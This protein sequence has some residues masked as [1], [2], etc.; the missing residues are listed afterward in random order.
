MDFG[1]YPFTV[2]VTIG[3]RRA[4]VEWNANKEGHPKVAR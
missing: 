4:D 1:T 2:N 3:Q